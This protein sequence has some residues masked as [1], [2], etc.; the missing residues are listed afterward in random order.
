MGGL[1][2][3]HFYNIYICTGMCHV[4]NILIAIVKCTVYLLYLSVV[5]RPSACGLRQ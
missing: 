5:A 3:I 2:Y 4:Y 1:K